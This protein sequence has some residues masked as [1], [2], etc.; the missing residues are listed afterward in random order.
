MSKRFQRGIIIIL[1]LLFLLTAVVLALFNINS[2]IVFFLTPSEILEKKITY[3][4]K[5]RVG[6]IVKINSYQNN[7]DDIEN[8][9]VI[10]DNLNEIKVYYEGLLP[11]LFKEG[12][13]VVAEGELQDNTLYAKRVFAKHDE[14]YMPSNIADELKKSG[15]WN[16]QY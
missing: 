10:K 6:G 12:S 1:S 5:I 7:K 14:N 9:F 16:N 2:N 8:I 4:D 11:D 3:V 15:Y 13:G